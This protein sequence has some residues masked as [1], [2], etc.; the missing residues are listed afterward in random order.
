LPLEAKIVSRPNS[1]KGGKDKYSHGMVQD[2]HDAHE[3][4]Q[5]EVRNVL[6]HTTGR[7][8]S[9]GT[10]QGTWCSRSGTWGGSGWP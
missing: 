3:T 1:E 2:G 5:D 6:E 10:D 8:S 9:S 7:S 4:D